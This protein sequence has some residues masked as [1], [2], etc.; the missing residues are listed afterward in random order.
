MRAECTETFTTAN[1]IFMKRKTITVQIVALISGALG[2][3]LLGSFALD[4]LNK[5][6]G[7]LAIFFA[8]LG[9]LWVGAVGGIYLFWRS[10]QRFYARCREAQS[11]AASRSRQSIEPWTLK[12]FED[13]PTNGGRRGE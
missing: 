7:G 11:L 5:G 10:N 13:R 6:Q 4:Y 12:S 8:C 1:R 9:F 3:I 2:F